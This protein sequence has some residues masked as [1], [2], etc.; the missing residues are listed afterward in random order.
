M[1]PTQKIR[2]K[3]CS[4]PSTPTIYVAIQ[5]IC[6]EG[7]TFCAPEQQVL[8]GFAHLRSRY[9]QNFAQHSASNEESTRRID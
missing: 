2:L 4:R 1:M 8:A 5:A 3:I 7:L 9:Q 6:K